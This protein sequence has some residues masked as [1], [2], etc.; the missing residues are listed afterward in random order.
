[1][2]SDPVV[3]ESF[4]GRQEIIELL[5]K[6]ASALKSGYRQNVAIIGHQQ[7]GKTSIL[8][9]FLHT[10]KDPQ[11]L[12]IYVEIKFQALDYFVEQFSRSLLF[13]CL[14]DKENIQ[15]LEPLS[16]LNKKALPW[17]PKTV[18]SIDEI[19]KLL[20]QRHPEQA[21]SRLFELTSIAQQETGKHCIVVL[22]EFHRLGEFGIKNAFSDF[23][24]RI[25]V[26]KD[27]MYLL[28]S[29]SFTVS[30]KI[31]A[32]K[33]SLLFGNFER[34]Y[35]EPFDF[36]TSFGF[37]EK[38]LAPVQ[39]PFE[40]K[41]F[42]VAFTDGHPFFLET[43]T[44]RLREVAL[45]KTENTLSKTTIAEVL[46][47]L[48]FESQG[49]FYQFFM[50]LISPWTSS[51]S[52]GAPILV[53]TQLAKGVNKLKEI[54]KAVNRSQEETSRCLQELVERE[55]IL[56]TGVFYRFHDK[57][58]KF[59]I[60]HVY[61]KKELS[62]LGVAANSEDF[63]RRVEDLIF[64]YEELLK[65]EP[66]ERILKLFSRFQNEIVEFGEK[67]RQLPHFTEFIAVPKESQNLKGS[68]RGLIA[69][70]HGRCWICKVVEEKATEKEV[71]DLLDKNLDKKIPS[72]TRVLVALKGVDENARLLAKEKKIFTLSL[73][74]INMLMDVYG[75]LPMISIK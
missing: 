26:Q 10:F 71:L 64:E 44:T 22:D 17:I 58:F 7:L 19:L 27:T 56:K 14:K 54:S 57:I 53:L 30:K 4:F 66:Q 29:S 70:G 16:D 47:K 68:A 12:P 46:L 42:L 20:K 3:G 1:M 24:K 25:M 73:S 18:A 45:A 36:E 8:R 52:Q 74:R 35:L 37:L 33:L 61:E 48:L 63:V 13:E 55:L 2:F 75:H 62:L 28:S 11:I 50:K 39:V 6:R 67:R 65:I 51:G 31:L 69:K 5:L 15:A 41:Y 59:W 43:I 72:S 21:Y 32:E 34:I 60:R 23:G 9:H 49:V 40:L 38:K